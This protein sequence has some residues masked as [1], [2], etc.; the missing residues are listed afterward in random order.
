MHAA[1]AM[2]KKFYTFLINWY[3]ASDKPLPQWLEKACESDPDLKAEMKDGLDLSLGLDARDFEQVAEPSSDLSQRINRALSRGEAKPETTPFNLQLIGLAAAACLAIALGY[4]L[5]QPES[6]PE[7]PRIT[8]I[9]TPAIP[10]VAI[11][12][13]DWKNP[14][15]QE[16]EYV[17]ADAKGAIDFLAAS[18]LPSKV[19]N[20]Y[21]GGKTED[22]IVN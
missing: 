9:E 4:H 11:I 17:M 5:L 2:K 18:F 3:Q 12:P 10:E 22:A 8:K 7:A 13:P 1:I 20:P 14:L 21:D 15:D 16:I 6:E 19:Y